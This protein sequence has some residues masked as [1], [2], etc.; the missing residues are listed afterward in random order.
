MGPELGRGILGDCR[1]LL[2]SLKEPLEPGAVPRVGRTF[3]AALAPRYIDGTMRHQTFTDVARLILGGP[4]ERQACEDFWRSV[5][6]ANLSG[7]SAGT[8]AHPQMTDS[9][10]ESAAVALQN[11]IFEQ[12]P[13][14]F[15]LFDG[16]LAEALRS[17]DPA[18]GLLK[19][20]VSDWIALPHPGEPGFAFRDHMIAAS[21]FLGRTVERSPS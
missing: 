5:A 21:N 8:R 17:R 1:L 3:D 10:L 19:D 20:R 12:T 14:A 16:T 2:V 15:I 13:T 6:F 4:A 11:I 18:A 9:D 7:P